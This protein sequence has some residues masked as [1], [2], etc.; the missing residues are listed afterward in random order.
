MPRQQRDVSLTASTHLVIQPAIICALKP[1]KGNIRQLP[2]LKCTENVNH[3]VWDRMSRSWR[4]GSVQQES[5]RCISIWFYLQFHR[6]PVAY[7]VSLPLGKTWAKRFWGVSFILKHVDFFI[8]HLYQHEGCPGVS[9]I[10]F[11]MPHRGLE[12]KRQ[13]NQKQ[14]F[15]RKVCALQFLKNCMKHLCCRTDNGEIRETLIF[16]WRTSVQHAVDACVVCIRLHGGPGLTVCLV[17]SSLVTNEMQQENSWKGRCPVYN[18]SSC[19]M[20]V[21]LVYFTKTDWRHQT[22][23]RTERTYPTLHEN[24]TW[25]AQCFHCMP[26]QPTHHAFSASF[27]FQW[28]FCRCHLA[29]LGFKVKQRCIEWSSGTEFFIILFGRSHRDLQPSGAAGGRHCMLWSHI[30]C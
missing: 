6:G 13:M 25:Q 15:V 7:S 12:Q 26:C 1:K 11:N 27:T 3:A 4:R 28:N 24:P 18:T 9:S 30:P 21:A 20:C 8:S 17:F 5:S 2:H 10:A 29:W 19:S 16:M 22:I 14:L 23:R